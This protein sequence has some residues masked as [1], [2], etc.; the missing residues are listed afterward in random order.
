M[1]CNVWLCFCCCSCACQLPLLHAVCSILPSLSDVSCS[2]SDTSGANAFR[3]AQVTVLPSTQGTCTLSLLALAAGDSDTA[4]TTITIYRPTCD[5]FLPDGTPWSK[6]PG[7]ACADGT[8]PVTDTGVINP[9]PTTCCTAQGQGSLLVSVTLPPP[10]T[11][12]EFQSLLFVY[13]VTYPVGPGP[14][15]AKQVVLTNTLPALLTPVSTVVVNSAS[16][17]TALPQLPRWHPVAC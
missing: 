15:S 14:A 12:P 16:E 7:N 4:S 6:A 10:A 1:N 13:N 17:C 2:W 8:K 3:E 11:R 5:S 9:G